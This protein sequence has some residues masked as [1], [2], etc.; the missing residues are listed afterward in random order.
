MS[1]AE[2]ASRLTRRSRSNFYYAFLTLPRPRRE[3]LYAV[4]A[5]CRIVDDIADVGVDGA[6]D[7]ATQQAALGT[8]RD[9]VARCYEPGG[10]PRHPIARQLAAAVRAYKIP[11]EALEAIIDGVAMDV[12]GAVFET[13][14]DLLPYC[15]RVA[16]AVGL[17]CIEIFGYTQA[18]ARQYAV[19]LGTALQLTNILR[20]VGA[21]A[22]GGRVYLPRADMRAFGISADDLK[23]GRHDDAFV[24]LMRQ[25]AARAREF[26][27]RAETA[28]PRVDARSLV[29]ARIMGAIYAALLDQVEASGF[30]VFG[31]RITVPT[32]R[33]VAIAVRC[34]AGARLRSA[35]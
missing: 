33:K 26:Y 6:I 19:D 28:F 3:A 12:D 4:Y 18:S 29:P 16:S 17:C 25:Q 8:W 23:R 13:A 5:F 9:E 34:W 27:R 24:G 14:D 21:D 22:R 10:T 7:P 30:Q 20:D 31:D 2:L 35:A 32:R 15:Y 11:R 1:V